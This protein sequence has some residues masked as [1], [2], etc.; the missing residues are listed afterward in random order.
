M[1]TTST[2]E[3]IRAPD[4]SAWTAQVVAIAGA[5]VSLEPTPLGAITILGR[6]ARAAGIALC[7]EDV[8]PLHAEL[9]VRGDVLRA[10]GWNGLTLDVDGVS[11]SSAALRSGSVIVVGSSALVVRRAGGGRT[12]DGLTA[13]AGSAPAVRSLR[14]AVLEFAQSDC[15]VLVSGERGT[16][17]ELV[18]RALH[19]QSS[20]AGRLVILPARA[21]E[22]HEVRDR[23]RRDARGGTLVVTDIDE[24][25]PRAQTDLVEPH[26][27]ARDAR[28]ICTTRVDL[29]A[30]VDAGAFAG[31]VHAELAEL[32]LVTP[33][34]RERREDLLMLL[35]SEVGGP[36]PV[37]AA[38]QL[39]ALLR[40]DWPENLR[41]VRRVAHDLPSVAPASRG[42]SRPS[43]RGEKPTRAALEGL[44][45]ECGRSVTDLAEKA[46]CTVSDVAHWLVLEG[47]DRERYW[48]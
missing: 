26:R 30:L 13:L 18:A 45:E 8:A 25:S 20:R 12:T 19:T 15:R 34:V 44:L 35:T 48:F 40:G 1:S 5:P 22:A 4:I 11:T 33:P 42:P 41:D 23:A 21:F 7:D 28:L 29:L 14:R 47:I 43:R 39:R 31:H 46:A 37:L 9:V 17:K 2:T 16:G 32:S 6:T 3:A 36:L 24:L 27:R 10:E 38:S